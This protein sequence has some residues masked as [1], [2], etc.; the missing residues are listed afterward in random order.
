MMKMIDK[1]EGKNEN[2]HFF[3][4]LHIDVG[5][6]SGGCKKCSINLKTHFVM[7]FWVILRPIF[8]FFAEIPVQKIWDF[9]DFPEI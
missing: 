7:M 6:M 2:F 4:F 3:S 1:H 5:G 9:P 8:Q